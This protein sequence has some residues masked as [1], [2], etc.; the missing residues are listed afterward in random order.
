MK[1]PVWPNATEKEVW[2][3]VAS[4][5]KR[6][7]IDTFHVGGGVVSVYSDGAYHSGD[8]DFVVLT[9]DDGRLPMLM[10]DMGFAK[11]GMHYQRKDCPHIFIQFVSG[12]VGIGDDLN[13]VP[14]EFQVDDVRI[15]IYSPTDSVRDRLAAVAY[16]NG[17]ESVMAQAVLVAQNQEIDLEKI[18][19]WCKD[20]RLRETWERF[21]ELYSPASSQ[22]KI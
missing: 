4:T 17:G 8:L 19:R 16:H 2:F 9:F 7:G 1:E 3:Y 11:I 13:I 21:V 6:G 12:P 10:R 14:N 5:L 15:K 18:R 20:E 22:K